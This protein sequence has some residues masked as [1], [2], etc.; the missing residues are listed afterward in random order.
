MKSKLLE[1]FILVQARKR[2]IKLITYLI[3]QIKPGSGFTNHYFNKNNNNTM[4]T[5]I[6]LIIFLAFIACFTS[7]GQ[8]PSTGTKEPWTQ[9]QLMAPA[10]L[11]KTLNDSQA[12]QPYI[13]CIG[14]QAVIRGSIDIGPT[15]DQ[16]NL[17]ALKAQLNKLPK[18][19]DIVV[20]CGCCPFD[21]C[22]NIRPAFELLNNMQFK[23]QKLLNLPRNIKADWIDHG[24][25]VME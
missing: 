19:A 7:C 23:N 25:P 12:K 3:L 17:D 11:A 16:A 4:K 8:G 21:R 14:P 20:Y 24:Y 1:K 9:S 13:F 15:R 6:P 5:K 10:D 18:D 22:P 2:F